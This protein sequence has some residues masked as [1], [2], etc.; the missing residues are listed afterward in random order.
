[1]LRGVTAAFV[2]MR[3]VTGDDHDSRSITEHTIGFC[4]VIHRFH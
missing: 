4:V 2:L 1:M 3:E